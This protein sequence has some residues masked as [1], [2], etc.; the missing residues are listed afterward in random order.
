MKYGHSLT[1]T[2]FI[3]AS[4]LIL[5]SLILAACGTTTPQEQVNN[6]EVKNP[7]TFIQA[8]IGDPDTLDPAAAYDTTSG[9]A[10]EL[11]YDTL[12][13]Y[14]KESTTKFVPGLAT[15][16][17]ISPDGKT[18]RFHIRQGVKFSNGDELTPED[19]EYTFERGMVQDY[20]AGPQWMFFEPFF[21]ASS[22]RDNG[23]LM[24]LSQLT[25]A[26]NVDGEWVQFNLATPYE[27]FL[28]ILCGYW[29][30]I[31]DKKWSIEQGDWDG[32]QA[33]YEKLNN[34]E[35][36]S[37][38]LHDK[39]MGTGP[40]TLDYWDQ[41]V[42]ISFSRNDN[43][44]RG[45]ANFQKVV[46][47]HVEEWTTRKLMLESGDA[48]WAYVPIEYYGEME[49]VYGL[50]VY[51]DLPLVQLDS[52]FFVYHISD[53]SPFIGSGKLD[54]Q[55]IPVDFFTDINVRK[56]F[57]Y[58]F[59]WD[60]YIQQV[61][62]GHGIQPDS[63]VVKGLAYYNANLPR[64]SFDAAKAVELFKAA[65]DGQLWEKGFTMTLAYNQGNTTRKTACEILAANINALNPKFQVKVAAQ[66]WTSYNAQWRAYNLPCFQVGWIA[67]Y[68]DAHNFI[69]PWM[70]T[71]GPYSKFQGYGSQA[72]DDLIAKGINSTS[73]AERQSIYDQLARQYYD[74]APGILLVQPTGNRYFKDWVHGYY[75]NP[76]EPNQASNPYNL[77]KQ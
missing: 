18:Y 36:D 41:A 25:S 38:P 40:F 51:R 47:K 53:Q 11:V 69:V 43:Y 22:S 59:N 77:S 35:S 34:P 49:G 52:F 60:D 26:V 70:A 27:P 4:L 71:Y 19:V 74:D 21:G 64:Y 13:C 62:Q 31:V 9:E 10:L 39:M 48:D 58:S 57:C 16:W 1:R 46:I 61:L 37:W 72:I 76:A 42:E 55:G 33:S 5:S 24:P 44:W 54:G 50:T 32:T 3:L 56:A 29:A 30:C 14:D 67:D 73:P 20:S 2:R 75:F 7:D 63:P 45:K 17:A 6:E 23:T 12:I 66:E 65:W 15:E 28:Q 68:L 8:D